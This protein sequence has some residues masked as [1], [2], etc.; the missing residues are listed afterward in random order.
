M[1]KSAILT[2]ICIAGFS[3]TN[4]YAENPVIINN[5]NNNNPPTQN[6]NCN[7]NQS[8]APQTSDAQRPGTYYRSNPS[9]GTDTIYTTGDKTPYI[10]DNNNNCNNQ[11]I[12]QP[13]INGIP[14]QPLRDRGR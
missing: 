1:M 5:N 12:I 11:P 10:V 4:C 13:Y 2:F 7:G 14:P 8:A 9:G 6:N 3:L